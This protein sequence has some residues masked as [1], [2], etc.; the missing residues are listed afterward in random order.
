MTKDGQTIACVLTEIVKTYGADVLKEHKRVYALLSD[1]APGDHRFKERRRIKAAL[2]TGAI[3][4]LLKAIKDKAGSELYINESVTHLIS[5]TDMADEVATGT[6]M[7]VAEALSLS[8]PQLST[9][10]KTEKTKRDA[11]TSN[12]TILQQA[13]SPSVDVET[14]SSV[15]NKLNKRD[16]KKKVALL[17]IGI[18]ISILAVTTLFVGIF[19]APAPLKYW[20]TGIGSGF[21]FT[22]LILGI[23]YAFQEFILFNEMCQTVTVAIP[24]LFVAN[25]ILRIVLGNEAY[26]LIFQ[27]ISVF[28]A[29]GAI[30]NAIYTRIAI[31]EKWTW[32]NIVM[33]CCSIFMFFIWPGNFTWTVWQWIIGIGGGLILTAIIFA[34]IEILDAIGPDMFISL[35]IIL[36]LLTI[37]NVVLLFTIREKYLIIAECYMV[38]LS[39]GTI[40]GT[41]MCYSE[42]ATGLQVL[43]IILL[44]I[45]G[46][47]FLLLILG[48]YEHFMRVIQTVI[49]KI[50]LI[51]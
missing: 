44:L 32:P 50:K 22:G 11:V 47:A 23:A 38:M 46:G 48:S 30:A 43:N 13:K 51:N 25:I 2:E 6:I 18:A 26:G 17:S 42:A 40:I 24:I 33:A 12:A 8:G 21:I 9:Q 45:N 7:S 41:V 29:V 4:I 19:F 10:S 1:M 39:I 28:M 3:D 20:E 15:K 14:I 31:E 37:A 16:Q 5:Q 49:D 35:S 27:I 36:L 34:V